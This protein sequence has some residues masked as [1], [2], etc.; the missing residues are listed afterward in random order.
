MISTRKCG[1]CVT[2][3]RWLVIGAFLLILITASAI[4]VSNAKDN[5]QDSNSQLNG[6]SNDNL[7]VSERPNQRTN[8]KFIVFIRASHSN[9]TEQLFLTNNSIVCARSYMRSTLAD[10]QMKSR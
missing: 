7:Q 9:S 10:A 5:K 1:A 6:A 2:N 3:S 8:N 4:D